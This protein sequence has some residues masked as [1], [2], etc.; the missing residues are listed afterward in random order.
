MSRRAT[1]IRDSGISSVS[2]VSTNPIRC[3]K[4]SAADSGTAHHEIAKPIFLHGHFNCEHPSSSC[5]MHPTGGRLS[6]GKSSGNKRSHCGFILKPE[7]YSG[8]EDLDV[9]EVKTVLGK[10]IPATIED[11]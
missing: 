10:E 4:P 6:K 1:L 3:R 11:G 5:S 8:G 7:G 9:I 2:P